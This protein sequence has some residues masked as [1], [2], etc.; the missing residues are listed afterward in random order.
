MGK[1]IPEEELAK[2]AAKYDVLK[3]FIK[4]ERNVYNAI[5]KRGLISKLCKHMKRGYRQVV[6]NEELAESASKYNDLK[7]FQ[8]KEKKNYGLIAKRGLIEQLCSHMKRRKIDRSVDELAEVASKYDVLNEFRK[9][10]PHAYSSIVNRGLLKQLCG[11]MKR[12]VVV[13]DDDSEKE[14]E[15]RK[16]ISTTNTI[17]TKDICQQIAK[18]Y[19]YRSDF[20]KHSPR[21]Y[22]AAQ[23]HGWLNDV[24]KHMKPKANGFKRK[25]YVFKFSDG[26]A[27]VGLAQ[28]PKVRYN[29][30]L[31][32][33]GK[34]PILPHIKATGATFEYEI[35]TD[36]IHKDIAGQVEDAYIKKFAA[37]GWKM[38]NTQKG[39]G[40]GGTT[41]LYTDR[42]LQRESMKY[43]YIEDFR[44]NSPGCYYYIRSHNLLD[45]YCSH[46]KFNKAPNY[47]WTL[48]RVVAI[49]PECKTRNT[50]RLKYPGAYK[51]LSDA[52]LLDE[53]YPQKIS[54]KEEW[55]LEKSLSIVPLCKTRMEI[56]DKYPGA[57]LALLS[58]GLLDKLVLLNK[59]LSKEVHMARIAECNSRSDLYFKYQSTYNWALRKGLLDSLFESKVH[60]RTYEEKLEIIKSCK[61]RKELEDKYGAVYKWALKNKVLDVYLPLVKQGFTDEERIKLITRCS[62]R[63]ELHNKHRSVW[64]WAKENGLLDKYFPK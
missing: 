64:R 44:E 37:E 32:G 23:R 2:I 54:R 14:L 38:L 3:D 33:E 34:T 52:G 50:L 25:I 5:M 35:L 31:N 10:E 61:S 7:E 20:R 60:E 46:M 19:K 27:Y 49:V 55:T 62:S 9:K 17:L 24:C 59:G 45:K 22:W 47:Y 39:G 43:K 56:H 13:I 8:I 29:Q 40:L 18:E 12:R 15:R 11:N 41:K 51:V 21:E 63:G 28:D 58:A 42:R 6:T 36:W 4:N 1:K 30:H 53:Y 57:Y 26:Y 48:E 16:K